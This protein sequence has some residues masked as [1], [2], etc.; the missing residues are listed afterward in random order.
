MAIW[1]YL[2]PSISTALM[3]PRRP[4]QYCLQLVI[5]IYIHFFFKKRSFYCVLFYCKARRKRLDNERSVG[6]NTRLRRDLA[7]DS[8]LERGAHYPEVP[9]SILTLG[10]N[11]VPYLLI[12]RSNSHGVFRGCLHNSQS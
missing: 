11:P 7:L 6:R 4:K 8:L 9:S 5:Y 10:V 3:R 2:H 12:F 1:S